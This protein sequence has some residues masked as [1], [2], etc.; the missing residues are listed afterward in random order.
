LSQTTALADSSQK[1][2]VASITTTTKQQ[3]STVLKSNLNESTPA[4]HNQKE[5]ALV[6]PF[7]A[8]PY[9]AQLHEVVKSDYQGLCFPL[10]KD[11]ATDYIY[12]D[13]RWRV[14]ADK[15][16]SRAKRLIRK[17][18][19]GVWL[20]NL[21]LDAANY[22]SLKKKAESQSFISHSVAQYSGW[23]TEGP[24]GHSPPSKENLRTSLVKTLTA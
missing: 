1:Q 10:D 15:I 16:E 20:W 9:S 3:Q 18:S 19:V 24:P 13:K 14:S 17:G 2:T 21:E 22:K 5:I 12:A 6:K 7:K 8:I 4:P 11:L 23:A